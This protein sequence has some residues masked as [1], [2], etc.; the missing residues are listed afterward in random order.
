MSLPVSAVIL[1]HN[2]RERL[3][4]VLDEIE[5]L[6]VVDDVLV[7]DSSTDGSGDLAAARG[8]RVRLLR[9]GDIGAAGRN[10]AAAEA[11]NELVLMLDDD[12]YPTPG[13]ID[14]LVAAHAANDRLGVATGLVRDVDDHGSTLQSTELGSF[15]WWLRRGRTGAPPEG[16]ETFFFAEGGCMVRRTP[17]LAAGGFFAPYFFTLSEIDVTMR[18]A[19]AG[20][21]TRYFPDAVIDHLRPLAN[22]TPSANTLRLRTRNEQWHFWLRYPP[23]MAIPRMLFYGAFDLLEAI[24]RGHPEAWWDGVREAWSLRSQVLPHRHVLPAE[25][26]RRVEDGRAGMH[27]A[28]L[29]GQTRR[30]LGR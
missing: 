7:A 16:F 19:A 11:R 1:S 17:F 8:E 26:L 4:R 15:D 22:K 3:A 5:R 14:R 21:E 27:L 20:W 18:L 29:W 6:G 30:R 2:R 23:R 9:V 10:V 28:L 12:S 25:V 24:Y 13:A